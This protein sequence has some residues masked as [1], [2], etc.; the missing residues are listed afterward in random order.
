MLPGFAFW[1]QHKKWLARGVLPGA[2]DTGVRG[3]QMLSDTWTAI[4]LSKHAENSAQ[5]ASQ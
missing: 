2:I 3:C 4:G 5:H 1:Y